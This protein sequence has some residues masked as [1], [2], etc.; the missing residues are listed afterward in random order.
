MPQDI[1]CVHSNGLIDFEPEEV[2]D[3]EAPLHIYQC[4]E[5][6]GF[7]VIERIFWESL[8][9]IGSMVIKNNH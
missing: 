7:Q 1:K 4:R 5:L 8:D 3:L 6:W 2:P 9:K